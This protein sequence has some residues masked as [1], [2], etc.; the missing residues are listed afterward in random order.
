[1]GRSAFKPVSGY[2]QGF[3]AGKIAKDIL[4]E[5]KSPSSFAFK[6]TT[7][8]EPVINLPRANQLNIAIPSHMIANAEIIEKFEWEK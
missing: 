3:A 2:E 1:M 4:V 7:K 8:G 5:G 6:P